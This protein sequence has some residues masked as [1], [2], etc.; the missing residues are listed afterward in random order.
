MR[1][2]NA[3]LESLVQMLHE[4]LRRRE[5]LEQELRVSLN[6][7]QRMREEQGD[8]V[9]MV[10]HEFRTPLAIIATSAQQLGRQL[11]APA[12]K[13]LR[14]CQ[15]IR[16]AVGRLLGLVDDY[17]THDRMAVSRPAARFATCVAAGAAGRLPRWAH[18][19]RT[20]AQHRSLL[21]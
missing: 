1:L 12:E 13:S 5:T 14:R 20:T 9:A 17:L 19:V 2:P 7:E 3:R 4:E 8:F 15:N 6:Q 16:D 18:S 21:V 10:S 11:D